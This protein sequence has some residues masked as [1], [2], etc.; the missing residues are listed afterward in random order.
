VKGAR[1]C[2]FYGL[3]LVEESYL[4]AFDVVHRANDFDLSFFG[5]FCLAKEQV[6]ELGQLSQSAH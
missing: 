4:A 2:C 5:K 6:I 1:A 3:K